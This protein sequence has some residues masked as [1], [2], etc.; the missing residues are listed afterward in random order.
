MLDESAAGRPE[1]A[2]PNRRR[3]KPVRRQPTPALHLLARSFSRNNAGSPQYAQKRDSSAAEGN[4]LSGVH[5]V[6]L[7]RRGAVAP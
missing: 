7:C 3:Q 6:P 2:A 1:W 4:G 5:C